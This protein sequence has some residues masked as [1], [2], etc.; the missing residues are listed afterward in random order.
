[1]RVTWTESATDDLRDIEAYLTD[2][3]PLMAKDVIGRIVMAAE[4]LLDFRS[5]GAPFGYHRW[6]TWRPRKTR[7]VLI[8]EPTGAGITIVRVHHAR[9]DWRAVVD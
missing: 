6:R 3:H 4:W 7:Y 1:M 8:Y 5:A 2:F 9:Q